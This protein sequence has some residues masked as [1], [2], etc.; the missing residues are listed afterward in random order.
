[1]TS[2]VSYAS[3]SLDGVHFGLGVASSIDAIDILWPDGTHQILHNVKAD[4]IL[5]VREQSAP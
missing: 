5:Q 4:Q 1:M 2:S 3:A